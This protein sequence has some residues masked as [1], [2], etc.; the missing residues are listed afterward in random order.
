MEIIVIMWYWWSCDLLKIIQS[1]AMWRGPLWSHAHI[2]TH[3]HEHT[4]KHIDFWFYLYS[5]D[6]AMND[7]KMYKRKRVGRD[8]VGL[9]YPFM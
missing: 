1:V 8:G 6:A 9:N 7:V 2:H 4:Y 3:I 5:S